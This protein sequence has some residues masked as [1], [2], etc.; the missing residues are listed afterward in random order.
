MFILMFMNMK[1]FLEKSL[2]PGVTRGLRRILIILALG[3]PE[4]ILGQNVGIGTENPSEKLQV[5]GLVFSSDGGFKFPD[6]S[7][8]TRAI[9]S[10]EASDAT[11][12]RW[13]AVLDMPNTS[14]SF[15][16][17]AHVDDIRIIAFEW[18]VFYNISEITQLPGNCHFGLVNL[19]A[20]ID[21]SS[22]KF[23]EHWLTGHNLDPVVLYFL[24][25]DENLLS[26]VDYYRLTL[27]NCRVAKLS[28]R[29]EYVGPEHFAHLDLISLTY[30]DVTV[31]WYG[32]PIV[33]SQ[34]NP[35]QCSSAR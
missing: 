7:V 3:I 22:P 32:P 15:S 4:M 25:W 26:Y 11:E 17:G 13:I 27:R 12:A 31:Y 23:F 19:T 30:S 5:A 2:H 29:I 21:R 10:F 35:F 33:Q 18:D 28:Q 8:Q 1:T 34:G 9:T 14:G 20:E 6:G 16:Y 24:R